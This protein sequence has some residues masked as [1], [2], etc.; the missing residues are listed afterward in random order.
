MEGTR[1]TMNAAI[2]TFN[3]NSYMPV[4]RLKNPQ[5]VLQGSLHKRPN[6]DHMRPKEMLLK[7][8]FEKTPLAGTRKIGARP[9]KLM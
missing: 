8:F 2:V 4:H 1:I 5:Q 7:E 3:T 9:L 6:S